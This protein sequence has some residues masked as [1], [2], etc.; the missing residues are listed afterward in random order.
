MT[1]PHVIP[2]SA[3]C[4]EK[5]HREEIL[6]KCHSGRRIK[7]NKQS[8]EKNDLLPRNAARLTQGLEVVGTLGRRVD[9]A[10]KAAE[11]GDARLT[12]RLCGHAAVGVGTRVFC[13]QLAQKRLHGQIH[14]MRNAPHVLLLL[15]ELGAA[16]ATSVLETSQERAHIASVVGG[17]GLKLVAHPALLAR[18]NEHSAQI[19]TRVLIRQ[20][21]KVEDERQQDPAIV[22]VVAAAAIPR[23][24]LVL[25]D[26]SVTEILPRAP[27]SR[28]PTRRSCS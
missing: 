20:G 25:G 14:D 16:F 9:P 15:G 1:W 19:L 22:D 3:S 13:F 6:C 28:S 5:V 24:A 26:A 8:G 18:T 10:H 4:A 21:N 27:H 2:K 12:F 7:Q 11:L 17:H 23:N